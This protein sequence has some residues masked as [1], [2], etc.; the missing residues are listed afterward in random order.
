MKD[1]TRTKPAQATLCA[2]VL[3]LGKS[4]AARLTCRDND[5]GFA[6]LPAVDRA[7]LE[8]LGELVGARLEDFGAAITSA[9][10]ND[11]DGATARLVQMTNNSQE[12][13]L[14]ALAAGPALDR[15][16]ARVHGNLRGGATELTAGFLLDLAANDQETRLILAGALHPAAP[17]R[18]QRLLCAGA[19]GPVSSSTPLTVA[20]SV[21]AVLRG[22]GIAPPDHVDLWSSSIEPALGATAA[23]TIA[24]PPLRPGVLTL[25]T[26]RLPAARA[27]AKI[28]AMSAGRAMWIYAR[29]F[30][31]DELVDLVRDATLAHAVVAID[32]DRST[33]LATTLRGLRQLLIHTERPLLAWSRFAVPTTDLDFDDRLTHCDV[34]AI[35]EAVIGAATAELKNTPVVTRQLQRCLEL[36]AER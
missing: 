17:L 22:E 30:A 34:G 27:S 21:L 3:A 4:A 29:P 10:T 26:G 24:L 33:D 1:W 19:A 35:D 14:L 25:L 8:K 11:V 31:P 2:A 9:E 13:L 28:I 32:I 18:R 16:L 23:A 20:A 6:I 5:E 12:L 7:P 15:G 36:L